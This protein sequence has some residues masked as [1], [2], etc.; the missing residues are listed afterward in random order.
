[1]ADSQQEKLF[2]QYQQLHT[3][4]AKQKKDQHAE[5]AVLKGGAQLWNGNRNGSESRVDS[6]E[7]HVS[8]WKVTNSSCK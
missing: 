8:F 2:F 3:Q 1:M 6:I 4:Q 5:K 7:S